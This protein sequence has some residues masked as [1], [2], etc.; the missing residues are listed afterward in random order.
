MARVELDRASLIYE[1]GGGVSDVSLAVE[2]GKFVALLGPSGSGKSTLL[3]LVGGFLRPDA[4]IVVIGEETVAGKGRWVPPERRNLGMVFQQHAVWPHRTVAENVAYPLKLAKVGRSER[5]ERVRETLM[6]VGLEGLADRRPETLS[7]GQRQRVALARALVGRPAALLLDEP[8]AS[9]DAALRDRL[10]VELSSLARRTGVTVIH[11]THDRTEA[12]ALADQV[13]VLKDGRLEQIAPPREIYAS[14]KTP[15]VA[16]F[17]SDAT[18]IPVE[19]AG[20]KRFT[21]KGSGARF[22]VEEVLAPDGLSREGTL[23][24]RPQDVELV[25]GEP[26]VLRT[27]LFMG[28]SCEAH[29]KWEGHDLRARI[30]AGARIES[31]DRVQPV[32]ARGIFFSSAQTSER[33]GTSLEGRL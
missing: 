22:E 13:A 17:V 3:R 24:L 27:A 10:R 7:G 29:L 15:F 11:V 31:G 23:A 33:T 9:L 21:L 18:L 20:E 5:E 19:T 2:D 30:S 26:A 8:F 1:T 4:G 25:P 14:P 32:F 28:D 12:L 6:L 16:S